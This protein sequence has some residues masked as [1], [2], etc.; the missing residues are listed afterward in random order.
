MNAEWF[1][2][3]IVAAM[4]VVFVLLAQR[5]KQAHPNA[6]DAMGKPVAQTWRGNYKGRWGLFKF[7]LGDAHKNLNDSKLTTLVWTMRALGV[8]GLLVLALQ[9]WGG[10]S[11]VF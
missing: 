11:A 7:L 6:W 3:A 9:Y 4:A 5:L 2:F 1:L 8:A 10:G